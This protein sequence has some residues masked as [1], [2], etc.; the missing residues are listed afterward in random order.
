MYLTL[1]NCRHKSGYE[2]K[3]YVMHILQQLKKK[4]P[5]LNSETHLFPRVLEKKLWSFNDEPP[6]RKPSRKRSENVRGM[7]AVKG[8]NRSEVL[9]G[10][11][12]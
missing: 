10:L 8:T 12:D 4:T 3:F 2:S 6:S 9:V 1:M 7:I 11:K 5:T